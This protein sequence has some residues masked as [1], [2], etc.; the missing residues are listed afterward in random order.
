MEGISL[1][2]VQK[3]TYRVPTLSLQTSA[4]PTTNKVNPSISENSHS[5]DEENVIS[6][7]IVTDYYTVNKSYHGLLIGKGGSTLKRLKVETGTR[8]DVVKGSDQVM[9]KGNG[10]KIELAKKAIERTIQQALDHARPTHFLALPIKSIQNRKMEDF[11]KSILSNTFQC[12]GMDPSIVVS[13]ANLHITLGVMKLLGQ[14][15]LERAIKYMKEECPPIIESILQE[16]KLTIRLKKLEIMQKNPA[17]A[18]VLYI[19]PQ[20]ESQNKVLLELCKALNDKMI[21]GGFMQKEDRPLKLH[22]TLINTSNRSNKSD[23]RQTFDARP[24][25]KEFKNLDFGLAHLD[26]LHIMK[27]GRTGP[28]KTYQ[29]EGAISL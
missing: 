2:K 3:R 14:S 7:D 15:E 10:E 19:T 25:L 27:M 22:A 12:R 11:Q 21:E 6:Q 24:I 1:I 18:H 26:K 13:P 23:E 20:D 16:K 9:I 17:E 4:V 29:T 5:S 8:I 28:N